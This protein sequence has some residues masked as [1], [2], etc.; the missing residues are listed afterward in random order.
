MRAL[1]HIQLTWQSSQTTVSSLNSPIEWPKDKGEKHWVIVSACPEEQKPGGIMTHQFLLTE[2]DRG[3]SV[4][5]YTQVNIQSQSST[6][7]WLVNTYFC[8]Y[9]ACGTLKQTS[10]ISCNLSDL[11]SILIFAIY[12]YT[13][14][15]LDPNHSKF[16]MQPQ[17][18]SLYASK[19]NRLSYC[20][21]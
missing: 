14:V 15:I 21:R 10:H 8:T 13:I 20:P 12:K 6:V 4:E 7:W 18:N 5:N 9:V 2:T 19:L 16:C 1:C 17:T 3:R 11:Q